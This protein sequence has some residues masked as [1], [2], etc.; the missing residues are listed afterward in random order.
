M[1]GKLVELNEAAS[2]LGMSPDELSDLRSRGEIHGYRDGSSWKFKIEEVERVAD[3]LG[4]NVTRGSGIDLPSADDLH[5]IFA[6]EGDD[7]DDADSILVSEEELGH[8]TGASTI[9]GKKSGQSSEDSDIQI[10]EP[11]DSELALAPAESDLQLAPEGGSG[12]GAKSSEVEL[13]DAAVGSDLNLT[14]DSGPSVVGDLVQ[15]KSRPA[16]C[17]RIPAAI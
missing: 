4:V 16:I 3:D 9:I 13:D 10:S 5:D 8:S 2:M 15:K 11:D 17:N 12:V 6:D 14:S 7:A 1:A